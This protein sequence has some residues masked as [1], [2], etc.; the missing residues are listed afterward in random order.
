MQA[1][2]QDST[3][4]EFESAVDAVIAGD[5]ATLESSLRENPELVRARSTR[6]NHHDPPR[7]CAMLLHYLGANGV[8]VIGKKLRPMPSTS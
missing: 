7:H 1:V 3:V 4:L 2:H 5:L 6:L 8:E